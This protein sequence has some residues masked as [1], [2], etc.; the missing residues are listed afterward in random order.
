MYV[1]CTHKT[2]TTY[3]MIFGL[4][5]V[6]EIYVYI[7][8]KINIYTYYIY[9]YLSVL[10]LPVFNWIQISLFVGVSRMTCLFCLEPYRKY[11]G[12]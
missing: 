12:A 7:K 6:Y 11:A 9:I 4:R 2:N 5:Y 8:I 1:V 3:I 10:R